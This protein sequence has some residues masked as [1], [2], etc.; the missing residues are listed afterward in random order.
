[1]TEQMQAASKSQST[2]HSS[3]PSSPEPSALS[4]VLCTPRDAL[5]IRNIR[6][7]FEE[8][9]DQTFSFTNAL[10][11]LSDDEFR[12]RYIEQLEKKIPEYWS[13]EWNSC[14]TKELD[15]LSSKA[16]QEIVRRRSIVAFWR[17]EWKAMM[18]ESSRQIV[19]RL[20]REL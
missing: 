14:W 1:M 19:Q 16:Q 7:V 17:N 3:G 10:K 9:E 5:V 13:E 11:F 15:P 12:L 4:D 8:I 18:S 2:P 20:A 6:L